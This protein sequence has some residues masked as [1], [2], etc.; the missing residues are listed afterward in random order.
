[1]IRGPGACRVPTLVGVTKA[2]AVAALQAVG[3]GVGKEKS[4]FSGTVKAGNVAA[5]GVAPGTL[6]ALATGVDYAVSKG[7]FPSA[8][9]AKTKVRLK[10]NSVII[11]VKCASSGAATNGTIKLR[12]TSGNHQTLG[13]RAF[14]CPSGKA[15][16]VTFTVSKATAAA[17]RRT[18]ST[19]VYAFIVS[20]GPD[21]A[22]ASGRTRITIVP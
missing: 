3:C 10:G 15:R 17:L 7:A 11:S 22:A 18:R 19:K 12:K 1:V 2:Q 6:V 5:Q 4:V 9:V 8:R 21:G 13:T 16:N 14:Q 20:R